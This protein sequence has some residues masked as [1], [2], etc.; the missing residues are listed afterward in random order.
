MPCLYTDDFLSFNY[1]A[2]KNSQGKKVVYTTSSWLSTFT[3]LT[4]EREC[5]VPSLSWKGVAW[6]FAG[7][8]FRNPCFNWLLL[9]LSYYGF[10][11][12]GRG[13]FLEF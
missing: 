6:N 5:Q 8:N 10:V 11:Y 4:L 7:L 12:R 2:K 9:F 13:R 3:L 1:A